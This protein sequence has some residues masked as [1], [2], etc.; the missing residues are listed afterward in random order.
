MV[1]WMR[2]GK[3][4][5]EDTYRITQGSKLLPFTETT[6]SRVLKGCDALN[7]SVFP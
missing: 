5:K 2:E 4:K 3:G 6:K 1:G 7:T